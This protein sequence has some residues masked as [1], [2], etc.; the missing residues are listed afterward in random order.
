MEELHK[1]NM[2][3]EL[4]RDGNAIIALIG[5][6]L[7]GWDRRGRQPEGIQ[8]DLLG[9]SEKRLYSAYFRSLC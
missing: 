9:S 4:V 7:Q 8:H 6:N 2:T 1:N 3:I 5:R